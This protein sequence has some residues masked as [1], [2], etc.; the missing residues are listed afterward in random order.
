LANRLPRHVRVFI[1]AKPIDMRRSFEKLSYYV[2]EEMGEEL[3]SGQFFLF[4]GKNRRRVKVLYYD[5]TGLVLVIKKLEE[6]IFMNVSELSEVRE[7]NSSELSLIFSGHRIRY[8]LTTRGKQ[9]D[10]LKDPIDVSSK[11]YFW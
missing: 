8:S 5:D 10:R 7:I 9:R 1:Y 11:D 4:L 2:R 3:T 6:G